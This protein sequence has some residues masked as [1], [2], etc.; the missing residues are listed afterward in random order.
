MPGN[1]HRTKRRKKRKPPYR[2]Q[3]RTQ[4]PGGDSSTQQD[5]ATVANRAAVT[6]TSTPTATEKKLCKSAHASCLLDGHSPSLCSHQDFDGQGARV[7]EV[8]E[9]NVALARS[10][11]CR[12]C[13]TGSVTFKDNLADSKASTLP[14][15]L[16]VMP[17]VLQLPFRFL[18]LVLLK[19]YRST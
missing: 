7:L 4:S 12:E 8:E 15:T 16:S 10:V 19:C 2:H 18:V 17:V 3:S 9:L 11:W 14:L 1:K 6:A 13:G 5:N